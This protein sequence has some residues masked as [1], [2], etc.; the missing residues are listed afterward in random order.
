MQRKGNSC[1]G[2]AAREAVT[3]S[4]YRLT[5]LFPSM[6]QNMAHG[7]FIVLLYETV[8]L[9]NT[10]W[11]SWLRKKKQEK[12]ALVNLNVHD[13]VAMHF[14]TQCTRCTSPL[15]LGCNSPHVMQPTCTFCCLVRT[16]VRRVEQFSPLVVCLPACFKCERCSTTKACLTCEERKAGW[17]NSKCLFFNECIS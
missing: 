10:V 13:N 1:G 14:N 8:S 16:S 4:L 17:Q 2:R 11:S 12:K 6:R 5:N 3:F 7:S 15:P 9:W